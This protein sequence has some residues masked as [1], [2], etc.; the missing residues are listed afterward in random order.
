[1]ADEDIFDTF[2]GGNE[3]RL[4]K[5][6]HQLSL[7]G[8]KIRIKTCGP[9]LPVSAGCMDERTEERRKKY[10]AYYRKNS[11]KIIEKNKARYHRI[12]VG[13]EFNV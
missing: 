10:K 4:L 5:I 1:M 13:G 7:K 3:P 11:A 8:R 6:H 9:S 12:K 2:E